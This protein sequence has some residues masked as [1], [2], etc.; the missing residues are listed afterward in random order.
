MHK[1]SSPLSWRLSRE[2]YKLAGIPENIKCTV[3]S[4]TVVHN[5]PKDFDEKT[6]FIIALISLNNGQKLVSEIVDCRYVSIGDKVEPC[7][8][9]VYTD[10]KEGIITYGTKFRLVK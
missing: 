6:P 10:G 9:K 2:N 4:F 7:P 1:K 3:E 5:A 8:R